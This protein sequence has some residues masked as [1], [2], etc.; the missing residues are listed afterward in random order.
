MA[1][2]AHKVSWW[3]LPEAV[4]KDPEW[5]RRRPEERH[6]LDKKVDHIVNSISS[7]IQEFSATDKRSDQEKEEYDISKW[8]SS[9]FGNLGVFG[10]NGSLKGR[11]QSVA[12]AFVLLNWYV[13]DEERVRTTMIKHK[14]HWQY[15]NAGHGNGG[16]PAEWANKLE[17]IL[18]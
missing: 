2:L 16:H 11:V 12:E 15:E 17:P 14:I 4:K 18:D 7:A 10:A 1:H 13:V 5:R 9:F 6:E 3:M 8:K